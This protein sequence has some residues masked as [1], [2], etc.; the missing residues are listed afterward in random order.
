MHAHL[1]GLDRRR[2]RL[3]LLAFFLALSVPS[4]ILV[5]QAFGRLEWEGFHQQQVLA[6]E[7]ALRI[8]A[9]LGELVDAES[10]R[11]FADYGF[12]VVEGDP[13]A[14]Y[15]QRSPLSAF[16]PRPEVPGLIGYFQVDAQ[17]TFSS[18]WLPRGSIDPAAYGLTQAEIRERTA[19]EQRVEQILSSNRLVERRRGE[20]G[21]RRGGA[22]GRS[23]GLGPVLLHRVAGPDRRQG[24][25]RSCRHRTGFHPPIRAGAARQA[26]RGRGPD[27][28]RPSQ[29]GTGFGQEQ[30]CPG[31][32]EAG[33]A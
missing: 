21:A 13:R 27:R 1:R 31:Q 15:L 2:L 28:L 10:A 11:G 20:G 17:G 30:G 3:G 29:R 9:R 6:E 8:D 5:Y 18:P 16:P 25:R 19:A 4:A 7:L 22:Q 32:A 12:L 14:G 23:D 24:G 33:R 26:P